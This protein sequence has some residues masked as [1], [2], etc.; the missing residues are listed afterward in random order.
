MHD[1]KDVELKIAPD[2]RG[3]G[4]V[5]M[6]D[7]VNLGTVNRLLLDKT[8]QQLRYFEVKIDPKVGMPQLADTPQLMLPVGRAQLDPRD[9][10]VML[11]TLN[12]T[13]VINVPKLPA[14]TATHEFEISLPKWF[15]AKQVAPQLYTDEVFDLNFL[16]AKRPL[17][18]A[19]AAKN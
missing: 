19:D 6:S 2:F 10:V 13:N 4:T 18:A 3:W 14:D 9:D 8:A 5:K 17:T 16:V 7:G 15:G 12:K 11:P 1:M